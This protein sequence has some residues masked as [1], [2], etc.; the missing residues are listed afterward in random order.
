M[1]T[2]RL[3]IEISLFIGKLFYKWGHNNVPVASKIKHKIHL[4]QI[5]EDLKGS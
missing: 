5:K 2:N 4:F 3:N 1:H